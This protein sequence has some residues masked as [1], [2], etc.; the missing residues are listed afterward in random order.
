VSSL[1]KIAIPLYDR[2]KGEKEKEGKETPKPFLL[3]LLS[4]QTYLTPAYGVD[5]VWFV[6]GVFGVCV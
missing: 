5:G 6:C 2:K 4:I 3:L 1:A